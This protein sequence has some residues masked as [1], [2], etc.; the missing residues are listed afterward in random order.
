MSGL[1]E[2]L[3]GPFGRGV[4]A[5]LDQVEVRRRNEQIGGFGGLDGVRDHLGRLGREGQLVVRLDRPGLAL[6]LVVRPFVER[7]DA[8]PRLIDHLLAELDGFGQDDFFLGRQ[9]RDL[10]DLLQVHPDRVVDSDH[11]GR[12]S[13]ELL[14]GRLLERLGVQLDRHLAHDAWADQ[15]VFLGDYLDPKLDRVVLESFRRHDL[16]VIVGKQ[17]VLVERLVFS[18]TTRAHAG[19][20]GLF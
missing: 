16:L 18:R 11:V 4:L 2:E 20:L 9:E 12:K 5:G 15:T 17:L 7:D 1:L 19:G 13:F 8:L 6:G 10:A 3:L 14:G